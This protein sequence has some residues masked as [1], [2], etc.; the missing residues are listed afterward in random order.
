[1]EKGL[2]KRQIMSEEE[3][4][5]D[6]YEVLGVDKET[7][8]AD[9]KKAFKRLSKKYHPDK[10]GGDTK[11]FQEIARAYGILGIEENK[12]L[13]DIGEYVD[14]DSMSIIIGMITRIFVQFC[15]AKTKDPLEAMRKYF[16]ETKNDAKKA[17]Y[18][19]LKQ[20][21][22]FEKYKKT[23]KNDRGILTGALDKQIDLG[24]SSIKSNNKIYE[25]ADIALDF[26]KDFALYLPEE[27]PDRRMLG[28]KVLVD[29]LGE[30][31]INYGGFE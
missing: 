26:S 11:K 7:S 10:K 31:K 15:V 5:F 20:I 21:K 23:I 12:R 6:P 24:K 14:E 18:N 17:N 27:L 25:D 8:Q 2:N 22:S 19:I 3:K 4:E 29:G 30:I 16:K 13:F 1:M 9:I 28:R